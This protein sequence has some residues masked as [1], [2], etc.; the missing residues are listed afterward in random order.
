MREWIR[1]TEAKAAETNAA[2][3]APHKKGQQPG[4]HQRCCP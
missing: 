2:Q 4:R 3:L 1:L